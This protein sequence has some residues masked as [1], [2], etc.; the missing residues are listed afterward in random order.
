MTVM[1]LLLVTGL[2]FAQGGSKLPSPMPEHPRIF[3]TPKRMAEIKTLAKTDA[4]LAK[5]I[6]A[7]IEK[8]DKA[9]TSGV[10]QYLIP[11]GKRLLAQSR[12][13]LDRT[14]IL[15][16]A[17]RITGRKEYADAAIEE[18]LTVCRFKDWNPSHYLDTAEMA[19]AVGLGYDWLY[20][21]ISDKDKIEIRE[22]IKKHAFKT[23]L[24][25]NTPNNWWV[26]SHNNWNQVCNCGL[27]IAALAVAEDEPELARQIVD[28]ALASAPNGLSVYKP[29]GAYPEGPQY[30]AYGS[31]FSGM[32]IMALRDVCGSDFGLLKTPGLDVTGDYYMGM[33]S[34]TFTYFNYADCGEGAEATPM[35]YALSLLY[36]RPDYALWLRKFY[37]RQPLGGG[38]LATLQVLWY[39]PAGTQTD[40]QHTPKAKLYRGIQ[41]I[42]T[43]RTDWND[44]NAWFVGFKGGDNRA[45]HGQLDIGSFVFDCAGV[46]WATDLGRD[47]YNMPGYFGAQRFTYY[48]NNNRSHNTL[49]IGDQIQNTNAVC[50][51]VA[52]KSEHG[53]TT[54][55][56]DMTEAYAGQAE[57]VKRTVSLGDKGTLTITDQLEGVTK[58]VRWGMVTQADVTLSPD[59]KTATLSRSGKT[60]GVLLESENAK[61]FEIISTTPPTAK[62]AQN[63]G[64]SML[65]AF[66]EPNGGRVAIQVTF[67]QP[68]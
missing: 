58:P 68:R 19:T 26:A 35:M 41:D 34:P 13:S 6:D 32:M 14:T 56:C 28:R 67:S 62:E 50:K 53:V 65:A 48:R 18:M 2:A 37:E 44:P 42:V 27:T 61:K 55:V 45:N 63:Q 5:Q 3:L 25:V 7:L 1:T 51:I 8:A 57:S 23:S 16:F 22:A 31:T 29:D 12:R 15:A 11:D 20:D 38:R 9:K 30:W 43:M 54:A 36:H 10:S 66:A 24:E 46:R 40:F 59:G 52:F 17:Y 4:F 64:F 47:D 60:L 21:V 39:N 49:V 33:I